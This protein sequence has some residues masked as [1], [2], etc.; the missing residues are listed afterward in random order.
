M[1]C[2]SVKSTTGVT[3]KRK[4]S[5]CWLM[6]PIKWWPKWSNRKRD[7]SGLPP[8]SRSI[9]WMCCVFGYETCFIIKEEE[10]PFMSLVCLFRHAAAA[11]V[12]SWRRKECVTF[13]K[14]THRN[15]TSL[16]LLFNH[17]STNM[18]RTFQKCRRLSMVQR[19]RIMGHYSF[20]LAFKLRIYRLSLVSCC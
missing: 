3:N 6:I 17:P 2:P 5:T 14:N 9:E 1:A 4:G 8:F 10:D 12:T 19:R 15:N 16:D 13:A 18:F 11:E 7:D 20:S